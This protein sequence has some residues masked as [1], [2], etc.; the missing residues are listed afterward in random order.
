MNTGALLEDVDEDEN[1]P[2]KQSSVEN[3]GYKSKT[4]TNAT[5]AMDTG[6]KKDQF[7]AKEVATK[8]KESNRYLYSDSN[9][10]EFL[11]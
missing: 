7:D 1:E 2:D 4:A 9:T 5:S 3:K 6:E 10:L 11:Y 8:P